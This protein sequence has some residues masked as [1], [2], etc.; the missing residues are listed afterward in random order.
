GPLRGR[1]AP[2]G[3]PVGPVGVRA[4]G[5]KCR[6]ALRTGGDASSAAVAADA[7]VILVARERQRTHLE[8]RQDATPLSE[9]RA[10]SL[11]P[12]SLSL[13]SPVVQ[14]VRAHYRAPVRGSPS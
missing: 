9:L 11:V 12:L 8:H 14:N 10:H 2:A 5:L 13:A 7:T 6:T 1:R 4:L 3:L